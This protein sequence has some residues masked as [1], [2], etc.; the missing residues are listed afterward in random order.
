MT[1]AAQSWKT[2][3]R[4]WESPQRAGGLSGDSAPLTIIS[5]CFYI[6]HIII[7]RRSYRNLHTYFVDFET[8]VL[9]VYLGSVLGVWWRWGGRWGVEGCYM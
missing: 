5:R 7:C 6:N 2:S 9:R 8:N 4:D 1:K 3:C